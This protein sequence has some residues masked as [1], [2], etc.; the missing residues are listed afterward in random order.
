M[1]REEKLYQVKQ[2]VN[3]CDVIVVFIK[4]CITRK[5]LQNPSA[6]FVPCFQRLRSSNRIV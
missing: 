6:T 1:I 3:E 5:G 4:V 2:L